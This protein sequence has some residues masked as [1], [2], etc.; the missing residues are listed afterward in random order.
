MI[1]FAKE[2][3]DMKNILA[4]FA[5][6]I[7]QVR[8]GRA[9]SSLVENIQV[10]S[11]GAMTALSHVAAIS[12]PDARSI[13]VKPWD[14]SILPCIEAAI[15]KENLGLGMIA[16]SG[17]VRLTIPPLTEDRR[18]EF[19]KLIGKK[20]EEAKKSIR[21]QRDDIKK[22]ILDEERAKI[23]SEDQKFSQ[24]EKMEKMTEEF[25]KKIEESAEKKEKELME[26]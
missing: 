5:E 17:Q 9:S 19:V 2:E 10:E 24:N 22:T 6:D 25:N 20:M 16:E 21:K 26:V 15:K 8:T 4:F 3:K 23:I 11:Y 7:K 18:K 12:T 13:V 1:D 14:K